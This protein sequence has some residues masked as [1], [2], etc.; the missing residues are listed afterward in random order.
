MRNRG[1]ASGKID[2]GNELFGNH[3]ISNTAYGYTDKKA[4]N[5]YEA[6]KAYDLNGDNVIDEKDE[7]FNKLKIWKDKNSN[8]IIDIDLNY[9]EITIDENFNTV[10][11][12]SE[13]VLIDELTYEWAGVRKRLKTHGEYIY[14]RNLA[15]HKR[16]KEFIAA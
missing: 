1:I 6:L 14:A 11:Q 16:S 5:G 12:G 3:T 4:T 15:A 9:K 13:A 10:K 2:N 7:I 8:G